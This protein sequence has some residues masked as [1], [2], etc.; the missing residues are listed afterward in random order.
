MPVSEMFQRS[1]NAELSDQLAYDLLRHQRIAEGERDAALGAA[2]D[3][4][5]KA[6]REKLGSGSL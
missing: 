1:S 4:G 3:D 2:V 5:L 6:I